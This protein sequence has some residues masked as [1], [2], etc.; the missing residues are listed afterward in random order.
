MQKIGKEVKIGLA[1]IG[2]LLVAFG[3][4]LVKKMMHPGDPAVAEAT[5]GSA[6]AD[7]ASAAN[8]LRAASEKPTVIAATDSDRSSEIPAAD[9]KRSAWTIRSDR[10]AEASDAKR[11]DPGTAPK[12]PFA[13]TPREAAASP[14]AHAGS[15]FSRNDN[16]AGGTNRLDE[17][18]R[19]E[20]NDARRDRQAGGGAV[21]ASDSAPIAAASADQGAGAD[22]RSVFAKSANDRTVGDKRAADDKSLA[23][24]KPAAA[25]SFPR[26]SAD[27]AP[28]VDPFPRHS[29]DTAP[30]SDPFNRRTADASPPADPFPRQSADVNVPASPGADPS[31][32]DRQREVPNALT[33]VENP[34]L[35]P[36]GLNDAAADSR[37]PLRHSADADSQ[38][39][40]AADSGS[41]FPS[42]SRFNQADAA[43]TAPAVPLRDGGAFDRTNRLDPGTAAE[44][45]STRPFAANDPPPNPASMSFSPTTTTGRFPKKSTARADTSRRSSSKIAPSTPMPNDCKSARCCRSPIQPCCKRAIPISARSPAMLRPRSAR[46]RPAPECAP[47]RACMWLKKGTRC[48]R[49]PA[50]SSA[51]RHGGAKSINSIARRSAA[52]STISSRAPSC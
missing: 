30:P 40:G 13:A 31:V 46:C 27:A 18:Q 35:K 47:E 33:P 32:A 39:I 25:D 41:R 34:G 26:R 15:F 8:G 28:A 45:T 4:V 7:P 9:S 3:Y 22:S 19:H 21:Q 14:D 23:G 38:P 51:S 20:P 50:T 17:S 29:A 10:S 37:N 44:R 43:A 1:V 48:S 2:V 16:S 5:E 42:Q 49:S 52:T 36:T 12:D 6:P 11:V 24:G